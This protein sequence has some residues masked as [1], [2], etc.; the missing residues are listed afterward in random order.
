MSV[1]AVEGHHSDR[2]TAGTNS[3]KTKNSFPDCLDGLYLYMLAESL[4]YRRKKINNNNNKIP[5]LRL[6]RSHTCTG[7]HSEWQYLPLQT[8]IW[9]TT[10]QNSIHAHTCMHT[11]TYTHIHTHMHTHIYTHTHTHMHMKWKVEKW[12]A[13]TLSQEIYATYKG[14]LCITP[15]VGSCRCRNLSPIW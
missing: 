11:C 15:A 12:Y 8:C 5:V 10:K 6:K 4:L 7:T 1:A 9:W 3:A 2:A 13:N 14:S